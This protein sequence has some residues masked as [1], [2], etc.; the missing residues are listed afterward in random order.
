MADQMNWVQN[1]M[2]SCVYPLLRIVANMDVSFPIVLLVSRIFGS[3]GVY[4]VFLLYRCPSVKR[5]LKHTHS[6]DL[7]F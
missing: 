1:E 6:V 5:A 2:L 3:F 7:N 4:N